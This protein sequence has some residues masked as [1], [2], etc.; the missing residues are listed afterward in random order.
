MIADRCAACLHDLPN[1]GAI[2]GK[3]ARRRPLCDCC[4]LW[5]DGL[6]TVPRKLQVANAP[7]VSAGASYR[8]RVLDALSAWARRARR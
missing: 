2:S 5:L 8:G 3:T 7:P 4:C 1:Q 6:R